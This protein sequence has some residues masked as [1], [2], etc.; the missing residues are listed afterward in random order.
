MANTVA[1][2]AN[3]LRVTKTHQDLIIQLANLLHAEAAHRLR[4]G[5]VQKHLEHF[6]DA[7]AYLR[8]Y[9]KSTVLDSMPDRLSDGSNNSVKTAVL[10]AWLELGRVELLAH[11]AIEAPSN[12][13]IEDFSRELA[14]LKFALDQ[15]KA[16]GK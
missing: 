5:P 6:D 2:A 11:A 4:E 15:V 8:S 9:L 16:L 12:H 7:T 13:T 3:A 10:R 1:T 14:A